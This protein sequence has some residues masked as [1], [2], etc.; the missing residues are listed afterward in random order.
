MTIGKVEIEN[1]EEVSSPKSSNTKCPECGS[2]NLIPDKEFGELVCGGCGLVV[3]KVMLDTGEEWRAYTKEDWKKR[4]RR[5]SPILFSKHDKGLSTFIGRENSGVAPK[6]KREMYRLRRLDARSRFHASKDRNLSKAMSELDRLC[7]K[8]YIPNKMMTE[9]AAITYRKTLDKGLVKGRSID[10]M[11]A[12]CLYVEFRRN[13]IPR[14]LNQVAKVSFEDRN[15]I[16]SCYRLILR[17]LDIQMPNHEAS[18][19]VESIGGLAG[20][21]GSVR[22]LAYKILDEAKKRRILVGKSPIGL[23]AAALYI[24]GIEVASDENIKDKKK[25]AKTQ[26]ELAETSGVTSVTVRNLYNKLDRGLGYNTKELR[27]LIR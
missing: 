27:K 21:P 19:Y 8:L 6:K 25:Y 2:T 16:S 17:E 14:T 10:G 23:A 7:D 18:T 1:T 12:A 26:A 5:G 4:S 9:D 11:I 13:A 15:Y 3:A 24:A 20:V 22:T